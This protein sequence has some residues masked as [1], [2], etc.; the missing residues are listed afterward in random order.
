MKLMT[1][2]GDEIPE[3]YQNYV[4]EICE[5]LEERARMEFEYIWNE[6]QQT[7]LSN[8]MISD[9]YIWANNSRLS[10]DM[11]D[12][13]D[14]IQSTNLFENE[15]IKVNVMKEIIPHSLQ[16]L[17]GMTELLKRIP[18]NYQKAMFSKFI[19]AKYYYTGGSNQNLF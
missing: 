14:I 18:T 5:K 4:K 16:K 10:G 9:R 15:A 13:C 1:I 3:F 8:C 2:Q 17:V 19:G 11:N 6:H 12:L 7:Q